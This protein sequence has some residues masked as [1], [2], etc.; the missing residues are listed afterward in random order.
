[1][2]NNG[3]DEEV[4]EGA[5]TFLNWFSNPENAASWHQITGYIPIT[6]TAYAEL[7]ENGWFDENPGAGVAN[8]Q[9]DMIPT[10]GALIGNFVAIR[11]VYTAAMEEI[12]LNDS[13]VADVLEEAN[14]DANTL[15]EEYNLLYAE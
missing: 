9:L 8:M 7:Q 15:L 12:L 5:L 2:L 6:N 1:M 14:E 3:L 11:D 10:T 13:D 4:E